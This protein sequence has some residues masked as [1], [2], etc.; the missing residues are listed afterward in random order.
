MF[1]GICQGV[2]CSKVGA[3]VRH[4]CGK[5]IHFKVLDRKWRVMACG[6]MVDCS[7]KWF[8]F[9]GNP[10]PR[11]PFAKPRHLQNRA[12]L[13]LNPAPEGIQEPL[14]ATPFMAGSGGGWV[15]ICWVSKD[16][17][18]VKTWRSL[19]ACRGSGWIDD[20]PFGSSDQRLDRG[21]WALVGVSEGE[22]GRIVADL[23]SLYGLTAAINA[24]MPTRLIARRRL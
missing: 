12:C 19:V 10:L 21:S 6:C 3:F 5:S 16:P 11:L 17:D 13:I 14:P 20:L 4:S 22:Y 8:F 15:V 1:A 24:G 7:G 9:R 2:R 23:L 18:R